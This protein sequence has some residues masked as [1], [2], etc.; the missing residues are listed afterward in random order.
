LLSTPEALARAAARRDRRRSPVRA[1]FLADCGPSIGL[2]HLRRSLVLARA[3]ARAGVLCEVATPSGS[4]RDMIL[5]DGFTPSRWPAG[6]ADLPAADLV[7]FDSYRIEA[8]TMR[9]WQGRVALRLAIDD[10]ADRP[11]AAELVLNQN[12]F[13]HELAYGD[14]PERALLLGPD[15]AL[16]DPAFHEANRPRS[17]ERGL[18]SFGG[19]DDGSLALRAA[20]ALRAAGFEGPIEL[21]LSPLH[22]RPSAVWKAAGDMPGVALHE[23]AAMPALMARA[24]FYLGG[25]GTTVLEAA[26]A[27]LPMLPIAIA[28][29][30]QA[31]IRALRQRGIMALPGFEDTAV[32]EAARRLIA[33]PEKSV[34]PNAVPPGGPARAAARLMAELEHA[35]SLHPGERA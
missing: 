34:L 31:N 10:L 33:E 22:E 20:Q 5:A 29:N 19:S 30:Q 2:G 32:I 3:L 14:L 11:L 18:V 7:I 25:A 27:G 12:L 24:S 15:Y 1:L 17:E 13:A 9:A 21:A 4:E 8:E 26:A 35:T 23:A 28:G 6:A 16:I